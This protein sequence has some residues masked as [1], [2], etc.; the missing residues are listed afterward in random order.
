MDQKMKDL[1]SKLMILKNSK[2]EIN[3]QLKLINGE[4]SVIEEELIGIMEEQEIKKFTTDDGTFSLKTSM[5]AGIEDMKSFIDWIQKTEN[6]GFI[7]KRASNKSIE[8]Y[9]EET[10]ILPP[11]I[12]TYMK[13]SIS[14]RKK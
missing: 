14:T 12:N 10:G 8:E 13:T 1:S 2:T 9:F 11:G 4:I 7:Q 6:I 3:E 5:Y